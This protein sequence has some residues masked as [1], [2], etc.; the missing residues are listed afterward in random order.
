MG[1]FGTLIACEKIEKEPGEDGIARTTLRR[2]QGSCSIIASD[3]TDPAEI[4]N[5]LAPPIDLLAE[6]AGG[7]VVGE[8]EVAILFR[9]PSGKAR[10]LHREQRPFDGMGRTLRLCVLQVGLP[11]EEEGQHWFELWVDHKLLTAS[12]Y[13]I[14]YHPHP[15]REKAPN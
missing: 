6:V 10:I 2:L 4:P 11:V 3:A 1:P 7:D 13:D 9:T 14:R 5:L 15:S 12:P 8:L